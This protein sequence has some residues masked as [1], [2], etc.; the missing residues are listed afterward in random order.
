MCNRR[1]EL[2]HDTPEIELGAIVEL[3]CDRDRYVVINLEDVARY[4]LRSGSYFSF[5][6]DVVESK[7]YWFSRVDCECDC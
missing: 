4:P 2:L 5:H 6:R 1:Y 7:R 3:D